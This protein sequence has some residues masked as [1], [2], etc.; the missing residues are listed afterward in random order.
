MAG[1]R[2]DAVINALWGIA[3]L[4]VSTILIVSL[5]RESRA[6]ESDATD[7]AYAY[8]RNAEREIAA[9]CRASVTRDRAKCAYEAAQAA[10]EYQRKEQDLAAQ[11]V[12]AWWT[13]VTGGAAVAGVILSAFGVFLVW[14]TFRA[15]REGNEISR[16]A[17]MAE[18]RAWMEIRILAVG[19]LR[20]VGDEFRLKVT[21]LVKNIG[22]SVA[23]NVIP[24]AELL[25][26][27]T[28]GQRT[29]GEVA[30]PFREFCERLKRHPPKLM[31]QNIFPDRESPPQKWDTGVQADAV[32]LKHGDEGTNLYP[33]SLALGVQYNTIFD[34]EKGDSH[35]TIELGNIRRTDD[36]G[37]PALVIVGRIG[38]PAGELRLI[39]PPEN[40]GFVT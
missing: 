10:R 36:Q 15:A 26:E 29:I 12:T 30:G 7:R 13:Q 3:A 28:L 24:E 21:F 35:Q 1:S 31:A 39:H 25:G 32:Q 4:I 27:P 37:R 6:Y 9:S 22:K 11:W 2:R 17:M 14:R 5:T 23:L 8:A 20:Y 16:Q 34:G 38:V 40:L 18:S 33:L 19:D